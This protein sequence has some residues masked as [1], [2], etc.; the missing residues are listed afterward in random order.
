MDILKQQLRN[1]QAELQ[2]ADWQLSREKIEAAIASLAD[3]LDH[4]T[5]Q[6]Q[7]YQP[8]WQEDLKILG[9]RVKSFLP[10]TDLGETRRRELNRLL[11]ELR[12]FVETYL[13]SGIQYVD[14]WIDLIKL[15]QSDVKRFFM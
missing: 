4:L 12:H 9:E 10:F 13:E 6:I 7:N 1:L 5:Q 11:T 3:Y 14:N 15:L 2:K 8:F